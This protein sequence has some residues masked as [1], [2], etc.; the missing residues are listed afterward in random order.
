MSLA[1]A[2]DKGLI[3][4]KKIEKTPRDGS[5]SSTYIPGKG[6]VNGIDGMDGMVNGNKGVTEQEYVVQSVWDHKANQIIPLDVAIKSGLIDS[7]TGEY[8]NPITGER[9]PMVEAIRRNLVNAK[10]S[11]TVKDKRNKNEI[12]AKIS[13]K[14][15]IEKEFVVKSVLDPRTSTMIS[16]DAAISAGLIDPNTGEYIDPIT[17]ERSYIVDAVRKGFIHAREAD[18]IGDQH[19]PNKIHA[20]V[21][22]DDGEE[23]F[24]VNSVMDPRTNKMISL[25]EAIKLGLIDPLTGEYRDLK[26]GKTYTLEK[27]IRLNLINASKAD[28]AKDQFNR[29]KITV[30]KKGR[31]STY[32]DYLVQGVLDPNNNQMISLESA[33]RSGLIDPNTGEYV[34]LITGEK[35]PMDEAIRRNLVKATEADSVEDK[36]NENKITAKIPAKDLMEKEFV[37]KSVLDPGTNKMLSLNEAVRDGLID[38]HTGEYNHPI[39]G[40]RCFLDD[41]LRKG[42]V[43]GR[44]ADALMDRDD[45]NL[46][47]ALVP[48]SL[49]KDEDYV[50]QSVLD[51][52]TKNMVSLNKAISAGLIDPHTAE[53][54]DPVTGQRLALDESIRRGLVEARRADPVQDKF[55]KNKITA[56]IPVIDKEFV[57]ESVLDTRTGKVISLD[58]AVRGGLVSPVTGEYIDP[59]TGKRISLSEAIIQ[60]LVNAIEADPEADRFNPNKICVQIPLIETN[61][62]GVTRQPTG[63]NIN[64]AVFSTLKNDLDLNTPGIVEELSGTNHTIGQA[65]DA[66][67][68][69]MDPVHI[70]NSNHDKYSLPDAAVDNLVHPNAAREI[71]SAIEPRGLDKLIESNTFDVE[72]GKV[73]DHRNHKS[74]SLATAVQKGIVDPHAVFYRDIPTQSIVTLSSAI[75]NKQLDPSTGTV[76]NPRTGEELSIAEAI[77]QQLIDPSV[78]AEKILGQVSAMRLLKSAMDTSTKGERREAGRMYS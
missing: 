69:C 4:I 74:V 43:D 41:A 70:Q 76:V 13:A 61:N 11:D 40:R 17:R 64:Q 18:P 73:V 26:T 1:D 42:I 75:A 19:D 5:K 78:N 59:L 8:V 58:E 55:S 20:Y 66:G 9:L 12:T 28:P 29:N 48:V 54:I 44:E 16:L 34:N 56:K 71:L 2:I 46:I 62:I 22:R 65:F 27:A 15:L 33:I 37:V 35:F 3:D 7:N 6:V 49:T 39:T 52:K 23:E 77:N 14:D 10:K 63:R 31:K 72:S 36:H 30:L 45:S 21:S 60:G 32:E 67:L 53:Y 25:G 68:L 57:I 24:V 51:P 47:S 50:I 38:P